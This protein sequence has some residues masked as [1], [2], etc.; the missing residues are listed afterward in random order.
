VADGETTC[1][2]FSLEAAWG[3]G[4]AASAPGRVSATGA[5]SRASAWIMRRCTNGR[6]SVGGAYRL[7]CC[8]AWFALGAITK[9]RPAGGTWGWLPGWNGPLRTGRRFADD[10]WADDEE[11]AK[12]TWLL[13]SMEDMPSLVC[14]LSA[15][16]W[17]AACWDEDLVYRGDP[18]GHVLGEVAAE[19]AGAG[20]TALVGAMA[21]D[22]WQAT[23]S[24]VARLFGRGGS[25]RQAAIE[26]QLDGN[27]ALVAQ[28]RDTEEVRASLVPV[29]RLQLEALLAE[30]P[31]VV[32]ELRALV[33]QVREA[34]P[35][36]QQ[37]WVQTNIA[38]DQATQNIVQRGTLH[39]HPGGDG[40]TGGDQPGTGGLES[41]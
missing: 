18:G 15:A 23:R 21:T 35:A 20:G 7:P 27:A 25:A 30:H 41:R 28:A 37:S 5:A 14:R 39:V 9:R 24:G 16:C 17:D 22:A 26:A 13:A 8:G 10:G 4:G 36:P 33:A 19:L 34:L 1:P 6:S 32:E 38:R 29:W 40:A 2:S 31:D 3:S 11:P 12:T